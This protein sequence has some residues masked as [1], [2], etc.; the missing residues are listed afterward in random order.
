MIHAVTKIQ[1]LPLDLWSIKE[2]KPMISGCLCMNC[3]LKH[4]LSMHIVLSIDTL[5]LTLPAADWKQRRCCLQAPADL[6][7]LD[8]FF[9]TCAVELMQ[10]CITVPYENCSETRVHKSICSFKCTYGE[11]CRVTYTQVFLPAVT[12]LLFNLRFT[13]PHFWQP[14]I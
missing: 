1:Y 13:A 11:C 4:L 12:A 14:S 9:I 7:Q 5:S 8:G 3:S 6:W 10:V 2:H